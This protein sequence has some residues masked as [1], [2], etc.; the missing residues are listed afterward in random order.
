MNILMVA[1]EA[2]PFVKTGGL[3]DV[4]GALPPALAR[5]G[6]NVAVVLPRYRTAALPFP[7]LAAAASLP[8][9][10]PVPFEV[11]AAPAP[12]WGP[13]PVAVG[14]NQFLVGIEEI[15][16]MGVRYFFVD[17]PPLY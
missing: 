11:A 6:E 3:A 13:V 16:R 4:L 9:A 8:A 17:C 5:L 14:P 12:V 7:S 2:V 10:G 1:S 15:E